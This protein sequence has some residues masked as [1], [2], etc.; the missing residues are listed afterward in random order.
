MTTPA[1]YRNLIEALCRHAGIA[2]AAAVHRDG[3][4][5]MADVDFTLLPV[6]HPEG[7]LL[8]VYADFGPLPAHDRVTAL[9]RLL[10]LN[11]LMYGGEGPGFSFNRESGHVLLM[12]QTRLAKATADTVLAVLRST[13]LFA[14]RWRA[15]HFLVDPPASAAQGAR[16]AGRDAMS[17]TPF[18]RR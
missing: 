5:R 15:D 16:G 12:T 8:L 6:A 17:R 2:D 7:E 13:A 11:L 14:Q 10:E 18:S 4:L 3:N 9:Q 1:A